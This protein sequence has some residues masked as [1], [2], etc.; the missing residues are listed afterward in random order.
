MSSGAQECDTLPLQMSRT[1]PALWFLCAAASCSG[2]AVSGGL[3]ATPEADAAVVAPCGSS[4]VSKG[5]WSLHVDGTS[6]VVRWEAC[7]QG[8]P[9]KLTFQPETGGDPRSVESA[10]AAFVVTRTTA[11]P[12]DPK[13]TPDFAGTWY[14]HEAALGGLAP[15]TC[16]RYQLT[17]DASLTGRFCTARAS[18][19]ALRFMAIGDTNPALGHTAGTLKY[20]LAKNPDFVLHGGDIQYY[21]STLETWAS[22]FPIMNPMLR[23]GAFL[24]AIGNHESENAAEYTEYSTRFFGGAGFDGDSGYYR[25]ES[26]GVWFFSVDTEDPVTA[27]SPQGKW[28]TASLS[29]AMTKPGFRFSVVFFHKPLVTCGDTGDAP[30]ARAQLEPLFISSHVALVLQAHMHGYER[31]A[32]SGITYV[33]TAGGGGLIVEP[34]KNIARAYCDKRGASGNFYHATLFELGAPAR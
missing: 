19:E 4:G 32:F 27:D 12:L 3:P 10:E 22:W 1:L 11:A 24:P 26:A 29:D 8:S 31:F 6:A 2:P 21:A 14:M 20:A 13:A 9:A 30:V 7:R 17:A 15:S 23:Q 18:G 33:T 25:F 5:P 16:Y 28:L 34:D